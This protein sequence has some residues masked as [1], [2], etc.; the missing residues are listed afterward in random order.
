[1][2]KNA[3]DK[4]PYV[5]PVTHVELDQ[6]N[7]KLR[8]ILVAV[9][10][11]IAIT[12]FGIGIHEL[13]KTEPGW[14]SVRASSD[15]PNSG[16]EITL[17][18]DYS[19]L[20]ATASQ[21]NKA[22]ETKYSQACT[23]AFAIFSPDISREGLG[24]VNYVNASC[25][26]EISVDPALYAA[27]DLLEHY[28]DRS[29]FL[30][31]VYVEY[32][33]II[34]SESDPEAAN[35]DP[36]KNPDVKAYLDELI[37]FISDERM[38][39]LELLGNNRVRLNV[40]QAYLDY[41]AENSIDKFIDFGWMRNAFVVDYLADQLRD[42]GYTN[43]CLASYDGFTR[44]LMDSDNPF[45]MNLFHLEGKDISVPAVMEYL[46]PMSLVC[47]RS[48]P[49]AELDAWSYYVYEDG[50]IVTS[51]IDPADGAS[52]SALPEMVSYSMDYGCAE[53]MLNMIPV[54]LT[55]AFDASAA[56]SLTEKD[57]FSVWYEQGRLFYNDASLKLKVRE[58]EQG[59]RCQ[60]VLS[61]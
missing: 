50:S 52:K 28:S 42:A 38:I 30:A 54:F 19:D 21:V 22:L 31:P 5:K 16:A 55:D 24:N 10:F 47:L 2:S 57:V 26:Q 46:G 41:A 23:D 56:N 45:N 7:V 18:Y 35:N 43:G 27:F 17:M 37:G 61:K 12:A 36:A 3:R 49:L 6:S 20:G 29:I 40:D 60:T 8:W 39:S 48:Y 14:Q 32:D 25:N 1:M 51:M 9:F 4:R 53:I 13:L 15:Q 58:D 11:V 34:Q 44:N 59:N 33:R